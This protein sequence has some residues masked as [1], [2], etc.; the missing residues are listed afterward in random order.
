M[1]CA[2]AGA[3]DA[4]DQVE[5]GIEVELRLFKGP[6]IVERKSRDF[7]AA[8]GMSIWPVTAAAI[9]A[10]RRSFS[11]VMERSVAAR[12]RSILAVSV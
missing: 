3:I 5:A 1:P 12:R 8:S 2:L 4:D 10:P 6:H 11:S 9:S 7:H